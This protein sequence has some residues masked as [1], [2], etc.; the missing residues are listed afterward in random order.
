VLRFNT[1][2]PGP[3]QLAIHDIRGR[4]VRQL[5]STELAAGSHEYLWDGRDEQGSA[6]ASGQYF[7]RL[8]APGTEPMTRK[9]MLVR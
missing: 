5:V 9:L 8:L 2:A 3:V 6:V 4:L 7:A 1:R